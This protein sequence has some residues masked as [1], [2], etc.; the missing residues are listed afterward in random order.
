MSRA[1]AK[2][3][4]WQASW[5]VGR[6][7]CQWGWGWYCCSSS[8]PGSLPPFCSLHAHRVI[9]DDTLSLHISR[10]HSVIQDPA[11]GVGWCACLH[12]VSCE[13]VL[14]QVQQLN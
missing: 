5:A 7:L 1:W 12:Q 11:P 8:C 14:G 4:S 9:Q 10:S 3:T 13:T 2:H 6:G